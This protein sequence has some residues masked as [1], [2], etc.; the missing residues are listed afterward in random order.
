MSQAENVASGGPLDGRVLGSAGAEQYEVLMADGTRHVYR[1]DEK[2]DG[3]EAYRY[4]GR[5]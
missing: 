3:S 5:R 4:D 2:P 1:R